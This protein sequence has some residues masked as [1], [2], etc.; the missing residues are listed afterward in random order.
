[1]AD[2]DVEVTLDEVAVDVT[3]EQMVVEVTLADPTGPSAV[4]AVDA[5]YEQF[6]TSASNVSVTHNL[7]KLPAVTVIDSAG[8]EVVGDIHHAS[9]NAF[10]LTFSAPFSGTVFCN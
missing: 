6:F 7:A 1:M 4:G 5:H 8:D 9:A 10:T 2:F 3:L